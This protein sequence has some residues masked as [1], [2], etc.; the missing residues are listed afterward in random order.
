MVEKFLL[1]MSPSA[2]M[3]NEGVRGSNGK[4]AD[5]MARAIILVLPSTQD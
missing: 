3:Y 2:G 4:T 1:R 5:F